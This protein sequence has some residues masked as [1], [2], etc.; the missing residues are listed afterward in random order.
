MAPKDKAQ[1]GLR[2]L[3]EA[4]AAFVREHTDGVTNVEVARH[5]GLESDFQ[6]EQQNYLSW[7]V[8]GLLVK[9]G[10]VRYEKDGRR[11]VYFA[12]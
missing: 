12:E 6:G 3:K 11:R 1:Q 10:T 2:L 4:V 8:L 7:S 9:E 5:L